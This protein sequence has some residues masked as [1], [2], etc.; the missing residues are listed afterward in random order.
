MQAAID[1]PLV[2]WRPQ[3]PW[4]GRAPYYADLV[5]KQVQEQLGDQSF[6]RK[7]LRIETS[8]DVRL[9][10][11]AEQALRRGLSKVDRRGGFR[12]A[13][14][15]VA[16]P[17]REKLRRAL[18]K[19]AGEVTA[20]SAYRGI[21]TEVGAELAKLTLGALDAVLPAS[22]AAWATGGRRA[23]KRLADVLKVGDVIQVRVVALS[24]PRGKHKGQLVVA[25]EQVP[26][27]QGAMVVLD[28]FTRDVVAVV[29]G[30]DFAKS[31][32][33][34]A[35]K[36]QRQP[37]SA[38][39]PIVYSA[40]IRTKRYTP[41][42]IV[43][44]SPA[45]YGPI[46]SRY[47]Y[48]P[49]NYDRQ[50]RGEVRL[51]SALGQSLNLVAVKVADDIGIE[52]VREE[53]RTLGITSPISKNLAVALG[54]DSVTP[55]ELANAYAVFASGGK[56][57]TPRL[58]RR[59]V[60]A[61][62]AVVGGAGP[63][64]MKEVMSP[65][66]AYVM[67]SLLRAPIEDPKGTARGAAKLGH[68]VAGKTGTTNKHVDTWFVAYTPT[69]LAAVWL[70]H[71]DRQPLGGRAT[72]GHVAVP[73][74]VD[75]MKTAMAGKPRS[76]FPRPGSIE[77]A[78][79]DPRTGMRAAAGQVDAVE[80]VFVTGTAPTQEAPKPGVG[81]TPDTLLLDDYQ[82]G[83][84]PKP[85]GAPQ[86]LAPAGAPP[87]PVSQPPTGPRASNAAPSQPAPSAV[88]SPA[89]PPSGH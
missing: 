59:I 86:P 69:L 28:P 44:D 89:V 30:Y 31:P 22:E 41:S 19:E 37:G 13:D 50:F 70:G 80:E 57:A 73:I 45:V 76:E 78:R 27:V 14:E 61:D 26:E 1:A 65:A 39:K 24:A 8:V 11:A 16:G 49:Q 46:F 47:A 60:T 6:F 52:A 72:G 58:V 63:T 15:N 12:G 68:L 35:V 55:M 3:D 87:S 36:A 66:Q 53:A 21:V 34:R 79:V 17:Q 48:R 54:A 33:N 29:G 38:F 4:L 5:R 81:A 23:R 43:V 75:F 25:L 84:A 67:T 71:D 83:G 18:A 77:L 62:G 56:L 7:N 32:F 85:P 2:V 40:A 9:Q 42:T 20:G 10:V 82:P 74:W 51:R 64:Q 88:R